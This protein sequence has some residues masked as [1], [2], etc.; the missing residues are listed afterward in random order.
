[1]VLRNNIF[2]VLLAAIG[3]CSF[4]DHQR[5]PKFFTLRE[6]WKQVAYHQP[7]F[8]FQG[9]DSTENFS[10]R[11]LSNG[12]MKPIL[13][14]ADMQTS[15][16]ADG[17]CRVA[18][19]KIYWDL[20]GTYAGYDIHE[21]D[22]LTKYEH[23]P[24]DAEDY[25][26]LHT[27]LMDRNSILRERTMDDLVDRVPVDAANESS[28]ASHKH[29]VDGVTSATKSEIS[30]N[31]VKGGLYSCFT[32][33]HLVHG[34]VVGQ[35]HSYLDI[36]QSD[37]LLVNFLYSD[38]QD[39]QSY[40][41]RQFSAQTY[42]QHSRRIMEVFF[43]AQPITQIYLLKKMPPEMFSKQEVTEALFNQFEKLSVSVRTELIVR[44][45]HADSVAVEIVS[46]KL[47]DLTKSQ[48]QSYLNFLTKNRERVNTN[49]LLNI[50]QFLKGG[51]TTHASMIEVFLDAW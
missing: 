4:Q 31:V 9:L 51:K 10:V 47:G 7:V 28:K 6:E 16:C 49:S 17:S 27:L 11:L 1:M 46:T 26:K 42:Q 39:Y 21:D 41:L 5:K 20:L 24:F 29:A 23:T 15:V 33:W 48:L 3:F 25:K 50:R 30:K 2:L 44:I 12:K 32:L 19:I 38:Y 45:N 22:P 13:F 37:S 43:S 35:M 14:Y 40:A 34:N 36:I 8:T 18:R